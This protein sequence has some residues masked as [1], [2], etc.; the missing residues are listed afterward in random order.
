M[1]FVLIG[2]LVF[3]TAA[4]I[5]YAHGRYLR[6]FASGHSLAAASW[7]VAQWTAGTIAFVVA[8]KVSMLLIP[9]EAAGL[10]V[11]TLLAVKRPTDMLHVSCNMSNSGN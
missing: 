10:F 7:S 8:V 3:V 2:L 5:D 9:L 11:G 4:G 1:E 6:A